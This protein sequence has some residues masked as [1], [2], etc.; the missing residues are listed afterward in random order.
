MRKDI[1]KTGYVFCDL[2]GCNDTKLL[3]KMPDL[4]Y[5]TTNQ[6][7]SVVMCK[8]CG[9]RY[10]DPRPTEDTLAQCYVSRYYDNRG[11]DVSKQ[12]NRYL[13]QSMYFKNIV[14]GRF[15]DIG[16]ALGAF[17][18]TMTG[19]GW[20]CYGMDFINQPNKDLPKTLKFQSGSLEKIAY[21]DSCFDGISSWGVFEHLISPKSYFMEVARILKP[22]G[23]FVIM[24]SNGNSLWSRYAYK[25]DIPRHLHFFT[26]ESIKKYAKM[27]NLKIIDIDFTNKIYS[28]PATGRDSFRINILKWAGVPWNKINF[29]QTKLHLKLLSSLG[30]AMGRVLIYPKI[31]EMLK[32]SGI[33]VV[34]FTKD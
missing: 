29:P 19:L 32:L 24:V 20:D 23:L 12:R 6:E 16:C 14:P 17:S 31:E 13:R 1:I 22:R 7:F 9:H 28:R 5:Q 11:Q 2:C 10:L 3:F 33:M 26:V 8:N 34:Q 15:L 18:E 27:A 21:P 30:A 4:R 25:D